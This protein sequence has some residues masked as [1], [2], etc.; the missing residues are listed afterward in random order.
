MLNAVK[1]L[2]CY[3]WKTNQTVRWRC[4]TAFSMTVWRQANLTTK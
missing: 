1:H 4:F 3:R 2:D